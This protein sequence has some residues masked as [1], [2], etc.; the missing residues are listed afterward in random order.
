[1]KTSKNKRDYAKGYYK[2]NKEKYAE[3]YKKYYLENKDKI[4]KK[5]NLLKKMLEILEALEK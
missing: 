1:M 3:Y 2:D 4:L 5:Q